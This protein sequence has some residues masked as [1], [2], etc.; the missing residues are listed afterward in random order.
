MNQINLGGQ[1]AVVAP[2][3]ATL[4][5]SFSLGKLVRPIRIYWYSNVQGVYKDIHKV[6]AEDRWSSSFKQTLP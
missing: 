5:G 4:D 2:H 3:L 6:Y 1:F